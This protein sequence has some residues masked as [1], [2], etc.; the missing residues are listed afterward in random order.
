MIEVNPC[1][2]VISRIILFNLNLD[3]QQQNEA[4]NELHLSRFKI[5]YW[6]TSP[7]IFNG[8]STWQKI[9]ETF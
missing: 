8:G 3:Q 1:S 5:L 7:N 9:E 2:L 4:W 6:E